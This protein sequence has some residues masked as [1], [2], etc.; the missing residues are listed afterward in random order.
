MINL[1][2]NNFVIIFVNLF[3]S[4][5]L[6]FVKEFNNKADILLERL[7]TMADGKT[8]INLF[9][10]LNK[11]TLDAIANVNMFFI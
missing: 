5:L 8:S 2:S 4:V 10:E 6:D 11:A 1:I 3:C 9:E 7:R